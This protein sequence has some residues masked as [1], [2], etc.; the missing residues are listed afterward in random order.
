M[1]LFTFAGN[2]LP[3]YVMPGLPAMALL[4]AEYQRRKPLNTRVFFLGLISPVLIL[5]VVWG[6]TSGISSKEAEKTLLNEWHKQPEAQSS[7]LIYHRKRP[8]SAQFYSAGTAVQSKEPLMELVPR[9]PQSAFIAVE[10]KRL[11][12]EAIRAL[13]NCELRAEAR[14]R[15]LY[16]CPAS[17]VI[18]ESVTQEGAIQKG[19][20]P[21]AVQGRYTKPDKLL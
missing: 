4:I 12:A 14:S 1:L 2:I 9:L 11:N 21:K 3:S 16:F 7:L 8:F 13:S 18:Q 17:L 10:K 6:I 15:K 19:T 20:I 5:S